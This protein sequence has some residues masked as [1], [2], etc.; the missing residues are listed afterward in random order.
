[1]VSY[2]NAVS[3]S[4]KNFKYY[5]RILVGILKMFGFLKS[6]AQAAL[7]CPKPLFSLS[8]FKKSSALTIDRNV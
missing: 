5:G 4:S 8:L 3:I 2:D 1:M 6:V 7:K